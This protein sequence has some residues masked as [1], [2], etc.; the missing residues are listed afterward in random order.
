A[1]REEAIADRRYETKCPPSALHKGGGRYEETLPGD[2]V[3]DC[4]SSLVFRPGSADD[5]RAAD[6]G[7]RSDLRSRGQWRSALVFPSGSSRRLGELGK[8]RSRREDRQ[9]LE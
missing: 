3:A 5:R 7:G 2:R 9:R 4:G 1:G 6:R 8:S